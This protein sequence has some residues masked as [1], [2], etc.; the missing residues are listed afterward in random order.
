MEY[1]HCL[2]GREGKYHSHF[3]EKNIF[4]G[5][6]HDA[7]VSDVLIAIRFECLRQIVC[8]RSEQNG[9]EYH[10]KCWVFTN[11]KIRKRRGPV[12]KCFESHQ[13]PAFI[14]VISNLT[15]NSTL[16]GD[17]MILVK[18]TDVDCDYAVSILPDDI[19]LQKLS[20]K[21]SEGLKKWISSIDIN[22]IKLQQPEPKAFVNNLPGTPPR[23]REEESSSEHTDD[24]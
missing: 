18:F 17:V 21:H 13:Q 23:S 5:A 2:V 6:K 1:V 15:T 22:S 3:I 20:K 8:F 19:I 12:I 9:Q 11:N 10:Y 14:T 4:N 24:E 7:L 16:S